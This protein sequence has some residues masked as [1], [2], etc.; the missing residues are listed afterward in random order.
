MKFL[1]VGYGSIGKR[2]VDNL[3]SISGIEVIVCTKQKQ[4]RKLKKHCK[5]YKKLIDAIN[6]QPE[7]AIIAN[8]SNEHVTTASK[9]ANAGIHLFIEKPLGSSLVGTGRLRKIVKQKKL[10]TMIGC[11]LRFHEC[12]TKIKELIEKK[13]IGRIISV[14]AESGS[15]LPNWHPSE[16]YRNS[17]AAREDLGGGVVLTCIHEIDYLYWFFGNVK[18]VFSITGQ[19]GNLKINAEDLSAIIMKFQNNIIAELHLDY[20]QRPEIRKCKLIGTK[21][22]I[23]WDSG[24]N[25][26]KVYN[27]NKKRWIQKFKIKNYQRNRMYVKELS[28]FIE[29][30][31]QKK[32]TINPLD[33]GITTLEIALSVKK[34]SKLG[35]VLKI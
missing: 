18:N 35:K 9:L 20:F 31:K 32:Q 5:V 21:G 7:A 1:V 29:C 24:S 3:L 8:N 12:I 22:T 6:E 15:H 25:I 26:V 2:H 4:I 16:N 33:Q 14:Q 27:V 34:S 10:V 23:Y 13:T 19:Y 30:I 28:H 17:Y 11:N